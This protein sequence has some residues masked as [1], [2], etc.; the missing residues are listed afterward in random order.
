MVCVC[1][2]VFQLNNIYR[3]A[4]VWMEGCGKRLTLLLIFFLTH[5]PPPPSSSSP[6]Y[7]AIRLA[8]ATHCLNG[9]IRGLGIRLFLCVCVCVLL[10]L[11]QAAVTTKHEEQEEGMEG[12][13]VEKQERG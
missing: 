1:V 3:E 13:T 11:L 8:D 10:V 5:P 7:S 12:E 9:A 2:C 4:A 6:H